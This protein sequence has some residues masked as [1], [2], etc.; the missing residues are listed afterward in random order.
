MTVIEADAYPLYYIRYEI[1]HGDV[2]KSKRFLLDLTGD[3]PL[4]REFTAFQEF[5]GTTARLTKSQAQ[6]LA[7]DLWRVGIRPTEGE[8]SAGSMAAAQEHLKDLQDIVGKVL[9][10]A[11]RRVE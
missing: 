10:A 1:N 4:W 7:D 9:P 11:L 2:G 5:P 3:D 8:G 6:Q